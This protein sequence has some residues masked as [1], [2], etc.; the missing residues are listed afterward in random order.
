[1]V[2]R[3]KKYVSYFITCQMHYL[4]TLQYDIATY[5]CFHTNQQSNLSQEN[6]HEGFRIHQD[7]FGS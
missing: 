7:S 4:A 2:H 5:H 1:M 6:F 3:L